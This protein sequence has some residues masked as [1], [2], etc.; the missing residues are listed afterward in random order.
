MKITGLELFD[1]SIPFAQP[2]RLSKIYG[3][4]ENARAVIVKLHTDE[5]LW[6]WVKPI[7]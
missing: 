5:V 1:I 7:P 2:Y 6:G 4:L 3:T